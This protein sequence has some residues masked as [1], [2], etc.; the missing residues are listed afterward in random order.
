MCERLIIDGSLG[1]GGGQILRT[2]LSLAMC[3]QQ[4]IQV[5]NI[6][7]GRSKP[8]LMRAHLTAVRAAAEICNAQVQGAKLGSRRLSFTPGAVVP[9]NYRFAIG[10]A[11]ST[12][13]LLQTV[14][15][16]LLQ[17]SASSRLTLEGGTHNKWAPSADFIQQVYL[18]LLARMGAKATLQLE[19]HGFYPQ[20]GG[21]A[22]VE[23]E[24]WC[25]PASLTLLERGEP[26]GRSA[27][28]KVSFVPESVARRELGTVQQKLGW[29]DQE[30]HAQHVASPGPGNVLS[31]CLAY[32]EVC[33]VFEA[34]GEPRVSA[35]RVAKQAVRQVRDYLAADYPVGEYLADQLL[36]PLVLGAGGV[37]RTGKLSQHTRTNIK[38]IAQFLGEGCIEIEEQGACNL[39]RIVGHR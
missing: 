37:F 26:V 18:P 14:L 8:G 23:I 29:L 27:F 35:E 33:E 7:A 6:R 31:L 21:L 3:Q 16:A 34:H 36:L 19:R 1:E 39:I 15:P 12:T 17:A 10:T 24:P 38:V 13:L 9:G 4:P 20:G 32:T 22:Q 5:R 30:L 2:A 11:G 25:E 28:A